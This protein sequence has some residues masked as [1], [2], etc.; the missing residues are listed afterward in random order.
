MRRRYRKKADQFVIAVQLDLETEGF[1]Y[2]KWGSIQR[3]KSGD[4]LVN[5]N[6]DVYTID[7]DV[8]ADTYRKVETGR[9]VKVTPVWAEQSKEPGSVATK[10]GESF[11][12]AGDYVVSNREDGGDAYCIAKETFERMYEPDEDE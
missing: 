7:Q 10:E 1:S 11:Y 5:N 4:W 12:E 6:G 9:Y 2:H 8:F 3:C